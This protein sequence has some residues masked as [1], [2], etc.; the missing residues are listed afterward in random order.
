[1]LHSKKYNR[2]VCPTRNGQDGQ[3]IVTNWAGNGGNWSGNIRNL[4]FIVHNN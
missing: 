3:E 4:Y 1:M 2:N